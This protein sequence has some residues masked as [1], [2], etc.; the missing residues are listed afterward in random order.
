MKFAGSVAGM[1]ASHDN[2]PMK[3]LPFQGGATNNAGGASL[4]TDSIVDSNNGGANGAVATAN[5]DG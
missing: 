1:R 2:S 5:G 3:A 4:P